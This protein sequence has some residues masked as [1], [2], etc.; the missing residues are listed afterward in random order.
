MT[1]LRV[2]IYTVIITDNN[3]GCT[4]TDYIEV[5]DN[6]DYPLAEAGN[7]TLINCIEPEITLDGSASQSGTD[8]S[9][10][11]S[12][13]GVSGPIDQVIS[14]ANFP[15]TYILTVINTSNGCSSSDQVVIGEDTQ[16]A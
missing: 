15:G 2:G 10:L 7:P 5:I 8:I 13:P 9:Y 14:N 12:G 1:F 6:T 11:W 4:S 16:A 3:N